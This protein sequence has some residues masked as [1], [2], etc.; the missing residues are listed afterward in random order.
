M[1]ENFGVTTINRTSAST[2]SSTKTE[3][4]GMEFGGSMSN[5]VNEQ[6]AELFPGYLLG[7]LPDLHYVAAISGG[8]IYK[9]RL[10]KLVH[11]NVKSH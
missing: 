11:D 8:K 3:E 10:P 1:A 9:G 5:S 4:P 2:G 6:E 7:K